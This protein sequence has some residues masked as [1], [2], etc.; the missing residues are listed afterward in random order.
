MLTSS[1][2]TSV[3]MRHVSFTHFEAVKI[4]LDSHIIWLFLVCGGGVAVVDLLTWIF[5][6]VLFGASF[7]SRHSLTLLISIIL[8]TLFLV[9]CGVFDQKRCGVLEMITVM[10]SESAIPYRNRCS[11]A[12]NK[13]IEW[14][15]SVVY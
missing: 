10:A 7:L 2:K 13:Y 4:S 14:Y 1:R 3:Y 12:I 6:Q 15:E 11:H 9:I 5:S 8:I